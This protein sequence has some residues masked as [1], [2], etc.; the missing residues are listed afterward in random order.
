M[1]IEL[2]RDVKRPGQM[3]I[4]V[5]GGR[6]FADENIIFDALDRALMQCEARDLHLIVVQGGATGADAIAKAWVDYQDGTV[7]GFTEP[8]DWDDLSHAD[9]VIRTRNGK[10]YDA[11][12]GYRR[13]Q[14]MIDKYDPDYYIA[15]PGGGGTADMT[16]RCK[17]AGLPGVAF[18][19]KSFGQLPL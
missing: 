17:A 8:A 10:K 12:A 6:E 14:L 1:K 2:P 19:A 18:T 13:N 7:D 16:K 15:A 4:L 11:K 3:C 9:A 5:F